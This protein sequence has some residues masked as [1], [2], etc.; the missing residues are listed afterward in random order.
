[1]TPEREHDPVTLAYRARL[2]H[3]NPEARLLL[4][5][6]A[7]ACHVGRTTHLPGD[8]ASSAFCEGKRAVFLYIAGRLGLPLL[9]EI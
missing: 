2:D 5:D 4:A 7:E 9:P 6:L 8:P 1:M 3:R